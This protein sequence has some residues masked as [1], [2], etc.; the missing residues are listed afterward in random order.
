MNPNEIIENLA[1]VK[2]N[3]NEIRDD[4]GTELLVQTLTK[5]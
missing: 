3:F 2:G 1:V 5:K 4:K